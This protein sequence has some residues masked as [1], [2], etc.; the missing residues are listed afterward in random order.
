MRRAVRLACLLSLLASAAAA[1]S[2]TEHGIRAI[3]RGDYSGAARILRPLADNP[4]R[5]DPVAQFFLGVIYDAGRA[6]GNNLRACRQFQ[7][8]AARPGPLSELSSLLA[9]SV[10]DEILNA[11]PSYCTVHDTWQGAPAQPF[12]LGPDHHIVFADTGVR[13]TYG[14]HEEVVLFSAPPGNILLP[15]HYTPI[16]VTRPVAT[17]RHFFQLFWAR[18]T[19]GSPASWTVGWMLI[20]VTGIRWIPVASEE[21]LAV[22]NRPTPPSLDDMLG[23]VVVRMNASGEAEV[24]ITGGSSPRTVAIPWKGES[25]P[26][27]VARDSAVTTV[28]KI[29]AS[30][31]TRTAD[32]VVALA[33]GDLQGAVEILKPMAESWT[34]DAPAQFF[35]AGLYEAG[36]G[37]P[38]DPVRACVLYTRASSDFGNPFGRVAERLLRRSVARGQEFAEAC[39]LLDSVGLDHGFEPAA[40]DLGPGHS[41]QWTLTGATVTY[42]DRTKR[43]PLRLC[44]TRFSISPV[45][46]HRACDGTDAICRQTLRRDIRVVSRRA[47]HDLDTA[48][49]PVRSCP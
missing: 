49:T 37:V 19:G 36:L 48:A 46:I 33:R 3:L 24:S 4:A 5:P 34:R 30:G 44:A 14:E 12:V 38:V 42:R 23:L 31:D 2:S 45:E 6:G 13:I 18:T 8:A 47:G 9:T 39:Q 16:S 40:F 27:P 22:L 11:A 21:T 1:Q 32:G 26:R 29:D 41:V 20:E 25:G 17:R 43:V 28:P 10:R 35:M 7:R 15:V